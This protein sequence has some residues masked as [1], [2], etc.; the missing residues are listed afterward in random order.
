MIRTRT[1]VVRLH[2]FR[3]L[4]PWQTLI[5]IH[6]LTLNQCH[7][8]SNVSF[9]GNVEMDTKEHLLRRKTVSKI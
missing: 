3:E 9:H 2:S 6:E 7:F 4:F 8:L 1:P 5:T